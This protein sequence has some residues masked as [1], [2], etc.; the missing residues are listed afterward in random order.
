MLKK[1]FSRIG[2]AL[3]DLKDFVSAV[4]DIEKKTPTTFPVQGLVFRFSGKSDIYMSTAY[5]RDTVH[6]EFLMVK[7]TNVYNDA[8]GGL[9]AYQTIL[10]TLVYRNVQHNSIARN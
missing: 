5:Q 1:Y 10:Q 4:K 7:R 9:A 2:I 8:S 6:V 3:T